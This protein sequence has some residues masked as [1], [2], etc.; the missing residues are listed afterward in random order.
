ML[1]I[2][3]AVF[4]QECSLFHL[5]S[6]PSSN[7]QLQCHLFWEAFLETHSSNS[8]QQLCDT[9]HIF[10]HPFLD[11]QLFE[12][13]PDYVHLYLQ[14]LACESSQQKFTKTNRKG[15]GQRDGSERSLPS[16]VTW[17][18]SLG[19]SGRRRE[20]RTFKLSFDHQTRIV[21]HVHRETDR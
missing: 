7:T 4:S 3:K 20:P 11:G 12:Q 17:V 6:K 1:D 21:A 16:L 18:W 5:N 14:Y 8:F 9:I 19:P 2:V 13:H 10:G 15:G